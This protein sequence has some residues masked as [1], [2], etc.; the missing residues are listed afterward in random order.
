MTTHGGTLLHAHT[1][2]D[3]WRSICVSLYMTLVGYGYNG[4]FVMCAIASLTGLSIYLFM[5]IRLRKIIPALA[6]AT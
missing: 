4:V 3:G 1:V 5:Y 6:D 2:F